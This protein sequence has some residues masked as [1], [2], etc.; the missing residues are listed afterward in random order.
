MDSND[1]TERALSL[2]SDVFATCSRATLLN[3]LA[4]ADGDV[5]AASQALLERKSSTGSKRRERQRRLDGWV[6]ADKKHVSGQKKVRQLSVQKDG[7]RHNNNSNLNDNHVEP[8]AQTASRPT[9]TINDVLRDNSNAAT[10]S[11]KR[12]T[13]QTPVFL[14]TPEQISSANIP[15]TLVPDILPRQLAERLF[16]VM[17]QEAKTWRRNKWFLATRDVVSP[18]TTSFYTD[19]PVGE[20]EVDVDDD[21]DELKSGYREEASYW[22]NGRRLDESERIRRFPRE[23]SE[24][25][26]IIEPV[27]NRVMRSRERFPLEWAGDWK[28]NVAAANC[29]TG[30]KEACVS[31]L[32]YALLL[33]LHVRLC[34]TSAGSES[35]TKVSNLFLLTISLT[36]VSWKVPTRSPTLAHIRQLPRF[37]SVALA[38]FV[39]ATRNPGQKH[40]LTR[41]SSFTTLL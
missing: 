40:A 15:C 2:L 20:N 29:Y 21:D 28:A 35:K 37:R 10:S 6:K 23:M 30:S 8:L 4:D 5:Q 41:S 11:T 24:A 31:F 1:P 33:S 39:C 32:V 36:Y 16:L 7:E 27:V 12:P 14:L 3:A 38:S 9:K 13:A 22:Y 17:L 18:H 26:D 25:K 34:R 19:R